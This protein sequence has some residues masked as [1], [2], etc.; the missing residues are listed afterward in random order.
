LRAVSG[1]EPLRTGGARSS[2]RAVRIVLADDHH[3]TRRGLRLL[4]DAEP[5]FEVVGQADDIDS[6]SA[7]CASSGPVSWSYLNR[8]LAGRL[9]AERVRTGSWD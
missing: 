7:R 8:R 9:V 4:I 2:W 5:D 3:L 1:E 6:A